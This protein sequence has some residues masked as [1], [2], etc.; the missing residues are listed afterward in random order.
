M[1]GSSE[2]IIVSN[3]ELPP[4]QSKNKLQLPLTFVIYGLI[5][6]LVPYVRA[7]ESI[8]PNLLRVDLELVC[9]LFKCY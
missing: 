8:F 1:G 3:S 7:Q 2:K 4:C 6:T 9:G 5:A